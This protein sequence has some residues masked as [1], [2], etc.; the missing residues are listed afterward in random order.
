MPHVTTRLGPVLMPK[1]VTICLRQQYLMPLSTIPY[2]CERIV[3]KYI[4]MI[5]HANG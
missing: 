2:A 4:S 3:E 5:D 1:V